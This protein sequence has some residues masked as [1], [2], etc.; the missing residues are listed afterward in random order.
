MTRVV[1]LFA[2]LLVWGAHAQSTN[3]LP[4]TNPPPTHI[5]STNTLASQA[6]SSALQSEALS[7]ASISSIQL[8]PE[9]AN[10]IEKG[11]LVLGGISVQVIKTHRPL[12]LFNPLAPP[13]YGSPEDNVVRDMNTGRVVGLKF[14]AISF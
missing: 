4:S 1:V 14:F 13:Q 3:S 9:K 11:K 7:T 6:A 8:R 10:E 2:A 5:I 12:Q